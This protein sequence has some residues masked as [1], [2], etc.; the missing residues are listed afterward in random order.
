MSQTEVVKHNLTFKNYVIGF[1]CSLLLTLGS[2]FLVKNEVFSGRVTFVIISIFAIEQFI[3]QV[4]LFL[5]LGSEKK[6]RFNTA[7]FLYMTM[8]VLVIVIG[9]MWIMYNL[10]YNHAGHNMSPEETENM[11]LEDENIHRHQ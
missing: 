1:T 6:P 9:T 3:L 4:M 7:I 2:F 8:T 11:L 5:H 10:D